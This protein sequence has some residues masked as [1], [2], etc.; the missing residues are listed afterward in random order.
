MA[1]RDL[2]EFADPND[3][4]LSCVELAL[5]AN[6]LRQK[7]GSNWG[8]HPQHPRE[9]WGHEAANDDT[10][11]GYWEWVANRMDGE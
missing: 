8:E 3:P 10:R 6:A 5:A 4:D 11:L 2:I 9:D 1:I 7:H